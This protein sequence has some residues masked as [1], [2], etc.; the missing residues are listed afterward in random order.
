MYATQSHQTLKVFRAE[1]Q[2]FQIDHKKTLETFQLRGRM[3]R[4]TS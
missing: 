1:K 2:V 3:R 4:E